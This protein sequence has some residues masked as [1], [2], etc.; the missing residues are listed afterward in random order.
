MDAE[1]EEPYF[2]PALTLVPTVPVAAALIPQYAQCG[3]LFSRAFA[4]MS[5]LPHLRCLPVDG[6]DFLAAHVADE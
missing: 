5:S 4:N 2:F 3:G 6:V 1:C